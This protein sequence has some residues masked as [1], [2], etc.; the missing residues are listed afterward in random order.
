VLAVLL[1]LLWSGDSRPVKPLRLAGFDIYQTLWPRIRVSA[2]A[3]IVEIDDESLARHGQWPWPRTL[4]AQLV[5]RIAAAHPAAIGIDI[6]MPERDRLSPG[7][8][9]ALLPGLGRHLADLLGRLPSND[10]ILAQALQG[11]RVVLAVAGLES[12][13]DAATI[14]AGRLAPMR[15]VGPDPV[16]FVRHWAGLLRSVSEIE[17]AAAGHGLVSVD[18][19]AGVVR[20]LPMIA[21]VG[22]RLVPGFGPEMLRV[23]S[24]TPALGVRVG[25]G[26]EAIGIGD[27]SIP[28]QRDGSVWIHFA[29]SDPARFVS[30]TSVLAG[31][32]DPG[33]F[34]KKLVL[35][36]VTAVGLSDYR[37]T[38][39][40]D[41]MAGVEIHAQLLEDLFDRDLL[42]R[43]RFILWTEMV[44]LAASG[45]VLVLLVP[46]LRA[47]K[48][49]AL[50]LVLS[51]AMVGVGVLFYLRFGILFDA[52][53]PTVALG[54]L[55]AAMLGVTL[56]ESDS[57]RR[58]LR[59]EV[60][61]QREVALKLAGELEAARRIQMGILPNPAVVFA[62]ER[63]VQFYAFLETA[64]EVG[65]DLYDFFLLD[66]ERVFV[67][68]GDVSGKGLPG[69]L[70]MAVSKTLCK[71]SALRHAG[72]VGRMMREANA[73]IARDNGEGLFVTAWAGVVNAR[74]GELQY[75]SAGHDAPYILSAASPPRQ[76]LTDG[77]GPPFCVLDDFPYEAASYRLAPGEGLCLITDGVTEAQ[78]AAGEFYGRQGLEELLARLAPDATADEVGEAIRH[79]VARFAAGVEPSD[80]LAI[81]AFRWTGV[82]GR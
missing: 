36:G 53:S 14:S 18:L 54:A 60:E 58:A 79:D 71:S 47:R 31:T 73:E 67:L 49:T 20:R 1:A 74:T 34:E 52:A 15:I 8:L 24:G 33:R 40:A 6:F 42:S 19:D 51:A 26:V 25:N 66:E 11:R 48:S 38:P 27:L 82:S 65:G 45:A 72:D 39:V 41:H 44:A 69:S 21:A 32:V 37:A 55:F 10:T 28:T 16:P 4:L 59:R 5:S 78:N 3:V 61:R 29:R 22:Q 64:R 13:T 76:R 2:P 9:P 80:D 46:P 77:G 23:A 17:S 43:P 50:L 70:F 75:C 68:I 12:P 57:Q 56:A 35:V 62:S 63:R 7:A 81:L 30:A